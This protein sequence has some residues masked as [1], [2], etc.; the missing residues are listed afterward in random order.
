MALIDPYEQNSGG[1]IDPF[2]TQAEQ[3]APEK[4][5]FTRVGE[6]IGKR[7]Q[8]IKDIDAPT[9]GLASLWATGEVAGLGADVIGQGL[10]SAY[11]TAMP[12]VAQ[13]VIAEGATQNR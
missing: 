8:N 7:W 12:Q 13:D 1:L 5:F 3:L 9:T 10:K 2:E 6:D 4:G 11:K